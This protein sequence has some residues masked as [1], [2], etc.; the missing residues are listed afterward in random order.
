MAQKLR[1]S[2]ICNCFGLNNEI[3]SGS[4]LVFL[5]PTGTV[6]KDLNNLL[7]KSSS[8]SERNT[9]AKC[10][11]RKIL[12]DFLTSVK[13]LTVFC[14]SNPFAFPKC[15]NLILSVSTQLKMKNQQKR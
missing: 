13:F 8:F 10:H 7:M 9:V 5:R 15:V 3:S 6:P 2:D 12:K 14:F 4:F 11:H 1:S